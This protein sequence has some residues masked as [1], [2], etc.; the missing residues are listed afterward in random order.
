M[1]V[2]KL[3]LKSLD[4]DDAIKDRLGKYLDLVQHRADGT[5]STQFIATHL[6][7]N[8]GSLIT[9]ATWMRHFVRSH[10][11]Y[12][13]DSVITEEINYDLMRAVDDM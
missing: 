4:V 1:G 7:Y 11:S 9:T 12:Q 13:F 2:V 6:T 10:P 8:A 3:Y 5:S